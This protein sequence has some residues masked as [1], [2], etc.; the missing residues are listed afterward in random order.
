MAIPKPPTIQRVES[1]DDQ[2]DEDNNFDN[3]EVEEEHYDS[4]YAELLAL[5]T[6]KMHIEDDFIAPAPPRIAPPP[7]PI[8]PP[9]AVIPEVGYIPVPVFYHLCCV[10]VMFFL[11][12]ILAYPY[13]LFC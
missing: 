9:P 11:S 1:E 8:S 7:V 2:S 3:D 5:D 10:V 12:I 4:A 13:A 6:E